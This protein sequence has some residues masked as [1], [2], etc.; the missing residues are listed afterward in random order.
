[1][2]FLGSTKT[3]ITAVVA[4]HERM[5]LSAADGITARVLQK[6]RRSAERKGKPRKIEK[7]S[8]RQIQQRID[9]LFFHTNARTVGKFN[10]LSLCHFAHSQGWHLPQ[11]CRIW[12]SGFCPE[13]IVNI[14]SQCPLSI[15]GGIGQATQMWAKP[16]RALSKSLADASNQDVGEIREQY[17]NPH[18]VAA[19]DILRMDCASLMLENVLLPMLVLR[20]DGSTQMRTGFWTNKSLAAM[21]GLDE[22]ELHA[23]LASHDLCLPFA[24]IDTVIILLHLLLRDLTVPCVPRVKYVR[25]IPTSGAHFRSSLVCWCSFAVTNADGCVVEV[26]FHFSTLRA[27]W[28][29]K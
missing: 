24:D 27:A 21:L 25:L 13:I 5:E 4:F 9:G 23:R 28:T 14:L 15:K 11:A 3:I 10:V 17:A 26:I 22:I 8:S 1:M 18:C 2:Y 29:W 7:C 20:F 6:A 12:S 19:L 16:S